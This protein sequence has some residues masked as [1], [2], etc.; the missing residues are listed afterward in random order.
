MLLFGLTCHAQV[1]LD[2][3]FRVVDTIPTAQSKLWKLEGVARKNKLS[4]KEINKLVEKASSF[5][6]GKKEIDLLFQTQKTIGNIYYEQNKGN[7]ALTEHFKALKIAEEAKHVF[8]TGDAH[9]HIAEDY[10]LLNNKVFAQKHFYYALGYFEKTDSI[11]YMADVY[12]L[13]GTNYK[14]Q[15]KIDSA[16]KYHEKCL[17]IRI[18]TNSQK[19]IAY[20][21]NNLAVTYMRA[22]DYD[23][24]EPFLIKSLEIKR[25]LKDKKGTAGSLINLGDI[26]TFKENY[27]EAKKLY[28]EGRQLALEAKAGSFFRI[29]TFNLANMYFKMGDFK[30][31]AIY[32]VR[33]KEVTDSLKDEE[34]NKAIAELTSQYETEKKDSEIALQQEQLKTQEAENT[35][36]KIMI[37]ASGVALL[38]MIVAIFFI[39]RSYK[40]N[41]RNARELAIKNHEIEEKNREITD[42][43]NY[44]KLIQQSLLASKEML[45]KNL[46]SYFIL[47]KPKDIVS[48]DFY[49]ATETDKG[50]LIACVDCTG[51]GVPGAFMSLIG[52]ENLDKVVSKTVNPGEILQQLNINVKRSLN[53]NETSKSRDGMDAAVLRVEK[54]KDGSATI[55]FAGANRPLYILRQNTQTIE[56]VKAT[57]QAVGGFTS[58]DQMFEQHQITAYKGDTLVITTDGYADQFGSEKNKKLT[59]KRFKELLVSIQAKASIDQKNNLEHFFNDWKG[60][61]EQ[62]DDLLVIGITI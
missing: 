39:Y 4:N 20:S 60:K 46:E 28:D 3:I 53:Q 54:N 27:K 13:L 33:S 24:A 55:T 19:G 5:I 7:E 9:D 18:K 25:S 47:Y 58:V 42:S 14:N 34:T 40:Q 41:K 17:A 57:K 52:K 12:N 15:D 30:N 62:L 1:K 8:Y 10:Q 37:I 36:Q 23:K 43:I 16:L 6:S 48:G 32:Y 21:Y 45:D 59:T 56:E 26:M 35:K 29:G 11:S 50:F 61:N 49:W 31:S 38:M 2:S 44:A 51:H 22:K